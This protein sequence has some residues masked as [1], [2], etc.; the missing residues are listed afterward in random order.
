MVTQ[1]VTRER[2]QLGKVAEVCQGQQWTD[3]L[4]GLT[5]CDLQTCQA[6]QLADAHQAELGRPSDQLQ[7]LQLLETSKSP[8]E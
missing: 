4:S 3:R 2:L 8:E 6:G 7:I 5:R 1:E